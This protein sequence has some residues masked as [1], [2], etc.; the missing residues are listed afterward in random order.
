VSG[1]SKWKK[2]LGQVHVVAVQVLIAEALHHKLEGLHG[3]Q[4]TLQHTVVGV[5]PRS[6]HDG[7]QRLRLHAAAIQRQDTAA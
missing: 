7:P 6:G 2:N 3:Q 1:R 4:R 5:L